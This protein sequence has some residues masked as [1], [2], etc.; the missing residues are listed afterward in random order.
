MSEDGE[1]TIDLVKVGE[2][3]VRGPEVWWMSH[4]ETWE[5]LAFYVVVVRGR[6]RTLLINTGIPKD[7]SDLNT[8]WVQY[9]G[10]ERAAMRPGDEPLES[11]RGLEVSPADVTDIVLSPFQAYAVSNVAAFP[12]ATIHLSRTGW[13]DFHAP[14]ELLTD[15]TRCVG[16]GHSPRCL[17]YLV[18][19]L[20]RE[21]GCSRTRMRSCRG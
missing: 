11:L 8:L 12:K 1:Y 6:G 15:H 10:D 13:L 21:C 17:I 16:V 5:T 7:L 14:V 9:S 19:T 3:D 20:G 4:W 18:T 2:A